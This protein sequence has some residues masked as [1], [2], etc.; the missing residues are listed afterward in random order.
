MKEFKI[1]NTDF[2]ETIKINQ[3]KVSVLWKDDHRRQTASIRKESLHIVSIKIKEMIS[4]LKSWGIYL[5]GFTFSMIIK[6]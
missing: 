6:N 1:E 5:D 4:E 2:T 3:C